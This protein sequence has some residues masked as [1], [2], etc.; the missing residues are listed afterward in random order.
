MNSRR[1]VV[2]LLLPLAGVSLIAARTAR[3]ADLPALT[4]SDPMAAALGF[5]LD[6]KSVVQSK[7]PTHAVG[8]TCGNCSHFM[9]PGA[10]RAE[11]DIF[12][13]TV[14]KAGWCAAYV[15]RT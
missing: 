7:Y 3:A 15:K 12:K 5:K 2:F 1:R 10:D 6:T 9:K 11:C 4:E 14:P 8:Q 13:K